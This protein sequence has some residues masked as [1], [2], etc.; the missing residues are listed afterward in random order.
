MKE[1][2]GNYLAFP[3]E[4]MSDD[5]IEQAVLIELTDHKVN[6]DIELAFT[7]TKLKDKPRLYVSFN[8]PELLSRVMQGDPSKE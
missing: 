6:G 5:N 3:K 7:A 4:G 2:P 1:L 8:L